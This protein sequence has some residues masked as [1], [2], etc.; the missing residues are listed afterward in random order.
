MIGRF[1]VTESRGTISAIE[2]ASHCAHITCRTCAQGEEVQSAGTNEREATGVVVG[3]PE[4]EEGEE[5]EAEP[6]PEP[7][8]E[9]EKEEGEEGEVGATPAF[10]CLACDWAQMQR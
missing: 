8:E 4:P 2:K 6:E 1:C 7:E 9:E 5:A 3:R 10:V